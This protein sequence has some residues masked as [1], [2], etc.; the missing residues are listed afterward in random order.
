MQWSSETFLPCIALMDLFL[1]VIV[2]AVWGPL[3]KGSPIIGHCNNATVVA[4]INK[5]HDCD[6][7]ASYMLRCLAFLQAIYDCG[8]KTIHVAGVNMYVRNPGT[9]ELSHNRAGAFLVRY[10]QAFSTPMQVHPCTLKVISQQAPDRTSAHWRA[11][12]NNFWR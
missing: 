4:Q 6:L 9:D 3:W 5:Q 2:T 1:I 7:W 12:F 11:I 10:S 8:V